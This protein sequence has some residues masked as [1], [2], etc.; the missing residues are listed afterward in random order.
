MDEV[1]QLIKDKWAELSNSQFL[2]F[3]DFIEKS[4]WRP[5]GGKLECIGVYIIYEQRV[6]IYVG[7]AGKGN[8]VLKYRISDLFSYS[9]KSKNHFYHTLTKKLTIDY[10]KKKGKTTLEAL[11]CIRRF[12]L[13][14]CSFKYVQT[15]TIDQARMLEQVFILLLNH[16]KHNG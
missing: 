13:E 4:S 7:S 10:S 2:D 3:K 8:H 11:D 12:Y 1:L 6:P 15:D 9:P 5:Q 14:K 16:P